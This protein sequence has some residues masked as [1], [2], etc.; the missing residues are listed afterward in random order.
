M[1]PTRVGSP[2]KLARLRVRNN[3]AGHDIYVRGVDIA[4]CLL[5]GAIR[6]VSGWVPQ[7]SSASSSHG[8]PWDRTPARQDLTGRGPQ[9][10]A[11][12][13]VEA[14]DD[15]LSMGD[16][17]TVTPKPPVQPAWSRGRPGTTAKGW[18][19][20]S[21]ARIGADKGDVAPGRQPAARGTGELGFS[22]GPRGIP[23]GG[24]PGSWEV[25][26]EVGS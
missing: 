8:W 15:Q 1:P 21:V 12:N 16:A 23:E 2:R 7:V 6:A 25:A 20:R 5:H 9:R 19:R 24:R 3:H 18:S 10:P 17:F 22:G 26:G 14:G 4:K 11:A 13:V